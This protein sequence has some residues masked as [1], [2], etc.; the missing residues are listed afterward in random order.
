[1]QKGL[2]LAFQITIII[3]LKT[4]QQQQQNIIKAAGIYWRV[5]SI[6]FLWKMWIVKVTP[7]NGNFLIPLWIQKSEDADK[8]VFQT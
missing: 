1:M 6:Y 5:N 8:V 7:F 2:K 3:V 4:E